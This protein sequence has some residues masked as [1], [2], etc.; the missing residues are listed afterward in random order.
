MRKKLLPFIAILMLA[1]IGA[2]SSEDVMP[3][4]EQGATSRTI[5]FT[6]SMPGEDDPA[7]RVSAEEVADRTIA[8]T[9]KANDKI[10]LLFVQGSNKFNESTTVTNI[11]DAGKNASFTIEIPSEINDGEPFD[12]YGVYGGGEVSNT[13][14]ELIKLPEIEGTT[15]NEENVGK[16]VMLR[17]AKTVDATGAVGSVN[18]EHVGFLFTTKIKVTAGS[19]DD[20]TSVQLVGADTGNEIWAYNAS[21]NHFDMEAGTFTAVGTGGNTVNFQNSEKDATNNILTVRNWLPATGTAWPAIKLSVNGTTETV[22][23]KPAKTPVASKAYYL[24][25]TWDGADLVFADKEFETGTKISIADLRA[26]YVADGTYAEDHYIEGEV[27]LNGEH[28]NANTRAAFIADGTAGVSFF[29]AEEAVAAV[30]L[31]AKVKVNLQGATWDEYAGLKQLSMSSADVEI[32]EATAT[33]PLDPRV[34]TIQ[35]LLDGDYQSELVQ[36]NEVEFDNIPTTYKGTKNIVNS[37]SKKIGVYTQNGATFADTNVPEGNG[38]FIGIASIHFS[39]PQL[40]VRKTADL[41]GMT[42][43]RFPFIDASPETL[44]FEKEGGDLDITVGSNIVWTAT[45]I[46][47]DGWLSITP[48]TTKVT[49]TATANSTTDIREATIT[50][51]GGEI[52]VTIPV[53]QNAEGVVIPNDGSKERPYTVAELF[54]L[55]VDGSKM[56]NVWIQG[57]IVGTSNSGGT[58]APQFSADNASGTNIVLADDKDEENEANVIPVALKS[59]GAA[60]TDLNLASN[61]GKYK[62]EVKL[63]GTIEKYF[64]VAG[65]KEVVEYEL[66]E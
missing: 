38:P 25:A 41:A 22:D 19:V 37:D 52:T 45:V 33:A 32:L 4:I 15:L 50:I 49:A 64:G 51:T 54:D 20:I 24:Y 35:E 53:T 36:I 30:P 17:F 11:T 28:R 26:N 58:W 6:A 43:E 57:F 40:I 23:A 9:W 27:I 55:Y 46:G 61:P 5:T 14:P 21:E 65:L 13:N 42:G 18:F 48:T 63:K 8:L 47:G 31:G 16:K 10:D 59:G 44:V 60:R 56:P 1:F 3:N 39:G 66:V 34:V 2:C 12:L 7:T 62:T 29:F